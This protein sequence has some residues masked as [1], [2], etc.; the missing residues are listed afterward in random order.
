MSEIEELEPTELKARLD[1]GDRLAVLDVREPEEVVIA[2][3]PHAIHVPMNEIPARLDELDKSAEWVVVCHHGMR[4]AHVAM[5]L[6]GRG[7]KVA[8]LNGGIDRWAL[9]VDPSTPRY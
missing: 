5:H 1:R 6:A 4:S 3:F 8:N 9:E 7:F 2:A